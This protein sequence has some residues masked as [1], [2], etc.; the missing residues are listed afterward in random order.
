MIVV[1]GLIATQ[2][3]AGATLAVVGGAL[4]IG[5]FLWW[6]RQREIAASVAALVASCAITGYIT[7]W[8]ADVA[9]QAVGPQTG[10][11]FWIFAGVV[12]IAAW[13]SRRHPGSRGVTVAL[14]NAA[15]VLASLLTA[16]S[17]SSGAILGLL[18]GVTV[19]A[20]RGG[21][22]LAVQRWWWRQR[23]WHEPSDAGVGS[24][25]PEAVRG[26]QRTAAL[27]AGLPGWRALGA[28]RAG[29]SGQLVDQVLVDSD[30]TL[31]IHTKAWS[32]RVTKVESDG[33]AGE[34]YAID[35]DPD[36]LAERLRAIV[37]A[38]AVAQLRLDEDYRT[39]WSV[40]AFWDATQLP[41]P[42]TELD[43]MT[44]RRTGHGAARVVLIRGEQLRAWLASLADQPADDRAIERRLRV[45]ARMLTSAH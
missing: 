5:V 30:R 32:G 25:R 11:A 9:G 43:V 4:A 14:A 37:D 24:T 17:P 7:A 34:T 1:T 39:L 10:V 8:G 40:V 44:D 16:L 20:W 42:V 28:R 36:Q 38:N 6:R 18:A 12:T 29:R 19:V 15:L 45:I 27:L 31:L 23:A 33:D 13:T 21:G 2:G 3:N 41:E 35:G 22:W 26:T